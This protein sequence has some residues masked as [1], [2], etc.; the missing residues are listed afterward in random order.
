MTCGRVGCDGVIV[1]GY[2]DDCGLAPIRAAGAAT[3]GPAIA[4]PAVAMTGGP[5]GT[6]IVA[7]PDSGSRTVSGR[8]TRI[9]G[10]LVEPA[11]VT[12]RDPAT[13]VL[14]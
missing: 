7:R 6:E 9:G 1:D 13:A 12:A 3:A 8:R 14:A 10:G 11:P 4:P 2:C 5:A